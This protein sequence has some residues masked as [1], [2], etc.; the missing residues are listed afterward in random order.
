MEI[1]IKDIAIELDITGGIMA[2][3]ISPL[4]VPFVEKAC[5]IAGETE[6]TTFISKILD[7]VAI[8][9][10]DEHMRAMDIGTEELTNENVKALYLSSAK[11]HAPHWDSIKDLTVPERYS[12]II[13]TEIN[14]LNTSKYFH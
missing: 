3:E 8:E 7:R 14:A 9:M 1:T 12:Y 5:D 13:A 11:I 6:L 10:A 4:A 2:I